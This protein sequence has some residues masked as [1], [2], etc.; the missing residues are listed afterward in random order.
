MQTAAVTF[1]LVIATIIYYYA[2]PLVASPA[3]ASASP[4]VRKVSFGIALPTIIVAGVINGSVLCKYIYVEKWR[5]TNVI[6]EKS[7]K[8]IGSWVAICALCWFVSWLVAEL[9]PNFNSM[10]AFIVSLLP[11]LQV[12]LVHIE[13]RNTHRI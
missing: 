13:E 9:I 2:G 4:M 8:S 1:Y 3:L 6:H 10:L 11:F 5:G 7:F 12:S